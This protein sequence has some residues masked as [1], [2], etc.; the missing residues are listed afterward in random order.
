MARTGFLPILSDKRPTGTDKE[1]SKMLKKIYKSIGKPIASFSACADRPGL[2]ISLNTSL[3]LRI[4]NI[5]LKFARL[6]IVAT[7]TNRF[8][9]GDRFL[10]ENF[11]LFIS[12]SVSE[13]G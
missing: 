12:L 3:A 8:N 6:N 10:K 1:A 2:P 11:L 7:K 4:K 13:A 9:R 5:K